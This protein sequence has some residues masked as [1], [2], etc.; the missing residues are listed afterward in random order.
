VYAQS[1][2]LNCRFASFDF[3]PDSSVS[4]VDVMLMANEVVQTDPSR[5]Y[6]SR[7][8]GELYGVRNPLAQIDGMP[9]VAVQWLEVDGP[10]YDDAIGAGYKLMFGDLP[11]KK[12]EN[13][14][15][16]LEIDVVAA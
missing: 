11:L 3:P 9:G 16:D 4:E 12:I 14:K 5:L 8:T 7:T 10:I 1:G 2:G 6:R 15:S 13:G